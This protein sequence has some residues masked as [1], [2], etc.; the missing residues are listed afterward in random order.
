[1]PRL[2]FIM[3]IELKLRDEDP[4]QRWDVG[5]V[6]QSFADSSVGVGRIRGD[7]WSN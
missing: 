2:A 7:A 3:T 1:M 6:R 5:A 4:L